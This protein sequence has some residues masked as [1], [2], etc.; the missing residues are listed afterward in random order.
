MSCFCVKSK[1][2]FPLAT[3]K[4]IGDVLTF[5]DQFTP[6]VRF[7]Y[8]RCDKSMV[9][10]EITRLRQFGKADQMCRMNTQTIV[11]LR[12]FHLASLIQKVS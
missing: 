9:L 3:A 8:S 12:I 1:F 11:I 2:P 6:S 10:A 4:L 7:A 5:F